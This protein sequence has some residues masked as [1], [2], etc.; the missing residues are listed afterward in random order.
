MTPRVRR[1]VALLAGLLVAPWLPLYPQQSMRRAQVI[2]HAGDVISYEWH[3]HSFPDLLDVLH[4]ARPDESPAR[5][6]LVAVALALVVAAA[7]AWLV[8]R[9]LAAR[10]RR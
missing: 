1:L 9:L 2:G 10:A 5:T 7:I 4:Y 3:F 8:H 6:L